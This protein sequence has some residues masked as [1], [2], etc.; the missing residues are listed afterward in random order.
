VN[1]GHK[2][3]INSYAATSP[4]EFF[5]VCS[6]YFFESPERLHAAYPDVYRQL[7]LFYRQQPLRQPLEVAA[8]LSR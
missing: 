6:E 3:A 8:G 1:T 2:H 7:S 4:A 5:A